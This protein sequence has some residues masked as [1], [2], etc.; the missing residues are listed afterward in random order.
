[1]AVPYSFKMWAVWK[2]FC[3]FIYIQ[4]YNFWCIHKVLCL[5]IDLGLGTQYKIFPQDTAYTQSPDKM[6]FAFFLRRTF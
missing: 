4:K 2:V 5:N 6:A 3:S 1:M